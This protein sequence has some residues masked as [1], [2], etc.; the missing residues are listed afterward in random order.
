MLLIGVDDSEKT[1]DLMEKIQ[2]KVENS[3]VQTDYQYPTKKWFD[4]CKIS[5]A[6]LRENKTLMQN[7]IFKMVNNSTMRAPINV[8]TMSLEDAFF[9][10]DIG[11]PPFAPVLMFCGHANMNGY[12][13]V[14]LDR[15]TLLAISC[16]AIMVGFLGCCVG[17]VREGDLLRITHTNGWTAIAGASDRMVTM[18]N[19]M[20]TLFLHGAAYLCKLL[21][22]YN[23]EPTDRTPDHILADK[24]CLARFALYIH[25][26][27]SPQ[28]DPFIFFN[29]SDVESTMK[30]W[31]RLAD[32]SCLA[33]IRDDLLRIAKYHAWTYGERRDWVNSVNKALC[34]CIDSFEVVRETF[35]DMKKYL[36]LDHLVT[37][38]QTLQEKEVTSDTLLML[39][40]GE[41][42]EVA[43]QNPVQLAVALYRGIRGN[44]D[45]SDVK[46][47]MIHCFAYITTSDNFNIIATALV[48]TS[49][50]AFFVCNG[51][52]N[53]VILKESVEVI[54]SYTTTSQRG[55]NITVRATCN[56]CLFQLSSLAVTNVESFDFR[57]L[58]VFQCKHRE[59]V[60]RD[61]FVTLKNQNDGFIM[62]GSMD[63]IITKVQPM[64]KVTGTR[65]HKY[66]HN[67][68][69]AALMQLWRYME[70]ESCKEDGWAVKEFSVDC[71]QKCRVQVLPSVCAKGRE[72]RLV[73]DT[74]NT[75][76][77][78]KRCRFIYLYTKTDDAYKGTLYYTDVHY[79]WDLSIL[80]NSSVSEC[81]IEELVEKASQIYDD[82]KDK[83]VLAT[84]ILNHKDFIYPLQAIGFLSFTCSSS[85]SILLKTIHKKH[86]PA[87]DS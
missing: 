51:K 78:L 17:R 36:M 70:K 40:R 77:Y 21:R 59:C 2:S 64:F 22:Q 33:S 44:L 26:P 5:F 27:Q 84:N 35:V 23:K 30:S 87:A 29:D 56:N 61:D 85:D 8:R 39:Q 69:N 68:F 62:L 86:T 53:C 50:T 31:H 7:E 1:K 72:V 34:T 3:W 37:L 52:N 58:F 32:K 65:T 10:L 83:E 4:E 76:K 66:T 74:N 15:L 19:I 47:L 24:R 73:S 82:N 25:F 28:N 9:A 55:E 38:H 45:H 11:H 41:W 63:S 46:M 81:S 75:V 80:L 79:W 20:K 67:E 14:T 43:K 6:E 71:H 42:M 60:I 16:K 12:P 49:E 57:E 48:A 13:E 18:D 54:I